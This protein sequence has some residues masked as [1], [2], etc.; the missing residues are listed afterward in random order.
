MSIEYVLKNGEGIYLYSTNGELDN[1]LGVIGNACDGEIIVEIERMERW[2]NV[3]YAKPLENISINLF[4]ENYAY[5]NYM[6]NI[7]YYE[8]K[9]GLC[10]YEAIKN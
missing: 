6:K 1:Y 3:R 5:V 8:T 9:E 4:V 10:S 2:Y 7:K